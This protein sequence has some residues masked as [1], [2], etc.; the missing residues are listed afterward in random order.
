MKIIGLRIEKYI[1]KQVSGH[2]CDFEYTDAEFER[3]ILCGILSDNRK[4]E[5]TLSYSEGECY[6]GWTSAS[7][8]NIDVIEVKKFN[9]YTFRPKNNLTIEDI[10]PGS[11]YDISNEVFYVS[12]NGGDEWYPGGNYHVNMDLFLETVRHK[13]NRPVWIFKGKSNSGKSF[14]AARLKDLEVYET[15]ISNELPE[16]ISASIIVLGNKHPF[17]ID[18]ILNK[19]VG[20][21][22]VQIVDFT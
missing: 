6:S 5:I 2:N 15:D 4:V 10:E 3:H 21:V 18:D 9:G 7:W 22:K 20:K 12:T 11:Q 19:L 13:E 17:S 8:G 1:D 14:L 16:K